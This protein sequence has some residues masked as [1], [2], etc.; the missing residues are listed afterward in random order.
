MR[1]FFTFALWGL[2]A[3]AVE[4]GS[5]PVPATLT[6]EGQPLFVFRS[7]VGSVQPSDRVRLITERIDRLARDPLF[8][9]GRIRAHDGGEVGWEVLA[10]DDLLLVV[11]SEDAKLEKRSGQFI[12]EMLAL[13]LKEI[14]I[15]DRRVKS[16]REV[17]LHSLYALGYLLGLIL[18]LWGIRIAC[19]RAEKT[20]SAKQD[21]KV[22]P[23]KIKTFE[24]LSADRVAFLL[25]G[26]LKATRLSVTLTLLYFFFPL[27]LGLFPW[28]AKLSPVL[29][30]YVLGPLRQIA[31]GL[32]GFIPNLFFI[33]LNIVVAR[34][35]LKFIGLFFKEIEK[36]NLKFSGFYPEWALP[37][38]QLVRALA[39]A[40]TAVIIFPYIPGSSSPAFQ[41]VSV[42][43]GVLV[44]LGSTS[45]VA[46][47]V[48]GIVI[49]Y[50]RSFKPGDRVKISDT[51]GD[52]VEK[53]LLA[54]R[55]RTVKNVDVTIPNAMVLSSHIINYSSLAQTD[56]LILNTEVTL[57]YDA[58]WRKV[59]E[60][61][62]SAA[63]KTEGIL[64]TPQPFVL[65]TSLDDSY[66]RYQIN[67]YTHLANSMAGLYSE[68]YQNIQDCFNEAGV[69]IMSPHYSAIRDGNVVT[70]PAEERPQGYSA[71]SFRVR[72]TDVE[73][74][75]RKETE[76]ATVDA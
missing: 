25:L 65:Q 3:F 19:R 38:F 29:L 23:I 2:S 40:F 26:V 7:R 71:P 68:L 20:L 41:G 76:S 49:T 47:V 5:A 11:T 60:L 69:E 55:V 44:S 70:I 58:P 73:Q 18:I 4:K 1:L 59:H 74:V 46:N 45:A 39:I 64:A 10:G 32:V 33:V 61:L 54:T 36:G 9:L 67:A 13:R 12:A 63:L 53:T 30:G 21:A 62:I 28:T 15:E 48:A 72:R 31:K 50:M 16:P 52:I 37:T 42:F 34:Y 51:M 75:D 24:L 43:L 22:R 8:D 17:F 56:G 27:V 35:F 6:V 57:G 14:L 66:V